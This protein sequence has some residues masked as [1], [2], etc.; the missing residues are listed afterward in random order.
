MLHKI[1]PIWGYCAWKI[2]HQTPHEIEVEHDQL[3]ALEPELLI[4]NEMVSEKDRSLQ[5]SGA[6]TCVVQIY[7]LEILHTIHKVDSPV[8]VDF[9]EK[10]L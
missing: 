9:Q 5:V 2:H 7:C 6:N 8:C 10:C 4:L 3:L 1:C